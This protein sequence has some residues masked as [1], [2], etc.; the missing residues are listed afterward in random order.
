MG[1]IELVSSLD[2]ILTKRAYLCDKAGE[3]IPHG[4]LFVTFPVF[5][6]ITTIAGDGMYMIHLFAFNKALRDESF[7][8]AWEGVLSFGLMRGRLRFGVTPLTNTLVFEIGLSGLSLHTDH[9][10]IVRRGS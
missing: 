8:V 7:L 5:K 1:L 2:G 4:N 3:P 6:P 10:V 9:R